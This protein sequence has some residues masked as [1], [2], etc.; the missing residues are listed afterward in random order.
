MHCDGKWRCITLKVESGNAL[1][2]I[3]ADDALLTLKVE[4]GRVMHSGGKV[5]HCSE[6]AGDAY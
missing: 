4:K 3:G 1:S 2:N 6:E 5:M